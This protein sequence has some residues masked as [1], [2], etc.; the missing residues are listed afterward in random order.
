MKYKL[1]DN[2]N[3]AKNAKAIREEVFIKEQ[4]FHNEFDD[5]D[6]SSLHLEIY[7]DDQ[8]IGCARM[9]VKDDIYYF[10][11]IAV[12]KEY[13]GLG[14]GSMIISILEREAYK[15]GVKKVSLSAQARASAFYEKMGYLKEGNEYFDEYCPHIKM[16]KEL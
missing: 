7:E 16:V 13:R 11:R 3:D 1:F 15:R 5:L 8:P 10:G 6:Y 14:Y 4:N 2:F 12:L 9:Y